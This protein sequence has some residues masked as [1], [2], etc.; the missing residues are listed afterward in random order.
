MNTYIGQAW[1]NAFSTIKLDA[2][3]NTN[4]MHY[5]THLWEHNTYQNVKKIKASEYFMNAL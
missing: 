5:Q 3:L 2:S 4:T 1:Q